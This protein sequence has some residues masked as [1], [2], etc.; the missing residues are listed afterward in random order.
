[1]THSVFVNSKGV[2]E[3]KIV[4]KIS[5][6]DVEQIGTEVSNL[7]IVLEDDNKA[8]FLLFDDT[9]ATG[10][11]K[12]VYSFI[13]TIFEDAKFKKAAVFGANEEINGLHQNI[14]K[15]PVISGR[16]RAFNNRKDA[17]TW[18]EKVD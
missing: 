15:M 6:K 14:M 2:I 8:V 11:E 16:F 10:W 5:L 3:I 7:S 1:M 9:E 18:L 12:N 13:K 17:E 4:G